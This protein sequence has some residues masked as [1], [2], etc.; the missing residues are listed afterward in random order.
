MER[1]TFRQINF[2]STASLPNSQ[3][4]TRKGLKIGRDP[5]T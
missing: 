4:L 1:Q 5:I 3:A 2:P